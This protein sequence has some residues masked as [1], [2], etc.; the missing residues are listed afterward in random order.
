MPINLYHI[1]QNAV[2]VFDIDEQK[3]S[4]LELVCVDAVR[5]LMVRLLVVLGDDPLSREA[6][7]NALL[8]FE[9]YVQ[10]GY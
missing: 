5:A 8:T 3:Q 10:G 6:Q 7:A 9:M 4:N 2:Q 1:I